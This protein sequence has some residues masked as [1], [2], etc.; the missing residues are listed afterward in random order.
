M[1]KNLVSLL[2]IK[3]QKMKFNPKKIKV[4][5]EMASFFIISGNK[6]YSKKTASYGFW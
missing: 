3:D 4:A 6:K 5:K 1:A 2:L